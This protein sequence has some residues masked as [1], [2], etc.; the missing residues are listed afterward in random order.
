[1][2]KPKKGNNSNNLAD[3]SQKAYNGIRRMLYNKELIPGQ[4][5]AYRELAERL[6]M[7]STPIIQAL[8]WLEFQGFVYHEPNRGYFIKPFDLKE[9]EEIYE[10]R[11]LLEL[12][13]LSEAIKHFDEKG[14]KQLK[15]ALDAHLTADRELF[16]K[17]RLFKNVEFHLTLASLSKMT[18][19]IRVLQNL[20]DLLL[21]K[22][23]GNYLPIRSLESQDH[24]H[25]EIY[26]CMLSQNLQRA[27]DILS[28]HISYV[29]KQVI[30]GLKRMMEERESPG[31]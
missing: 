29:E 11:K 2:G 18:T 3:H 4:K 12:S 28:Q 25:K 5:I 7:S 26:D 19:Q 31:F 20:F 30:A 24:E 8:K 23:G 27:H 14:A 21:L 15:I 10:L 6:E 17:E 13:L 1:M 9:I 22:Y 16:I